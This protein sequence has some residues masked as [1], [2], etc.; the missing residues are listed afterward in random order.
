[1]SEPSNDQR[2]DWALDG[3]LAFAEKT[4]L[5]SKTNHEDL[6]TIVGDFLCNLLHLCDREDIDFESVMDDAQFAH[7]EEVEIEQDSDED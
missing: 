3:L 5:R 6:E 7:D 4:G 1:V 2:A